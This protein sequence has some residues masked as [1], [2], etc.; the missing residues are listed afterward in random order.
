M[1]VLSQP[2]FHIVPNNSSNNFARFSAV[3]SD[4]INDTIM[5]TLT[6]SGDNQNEEMCVFD[7]API[8]LHK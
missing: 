3:R 1:R 6:M 5:G 7:R 2:G 8:V 4:G